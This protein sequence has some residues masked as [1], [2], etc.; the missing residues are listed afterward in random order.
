LV[1]FIALIAIVRTTDI[2]GD[3]AFANIA[4]WIL[5][6]SSFVILAVWFNFRSGFSRR[7]KLWT[8]AGFLAGLAA[9]VVLFRIERLSGELSPTF[10]F[11]FSAK[12]DR[13]LQ[14][15]DEATS[16]SE[17][18]EK[19]DLLATTEND[20]PQ[21]LGPGR[22]E[23]VENVKLARPWTE[24]QIPELIWKNKIGAGWS[25]FSVVGEH[26]VTMEQRG[27][28][29]MVTCYNVKSGKLEWSHADRARYEK[30]EA[31]VGPRGTPTIDGRLVF[32]QGALGH[33]MCLDGA[34]GKCVWEKNLLK[35]YNIPLDDANHEAIM[36]WGRSASPLV[37]GDWVIVP[38]GGPQGGKLV[39][40]AA[41]DK[42]TGAPVWE[43]GEKQASYCS[44]ALATLAGIEQVLIANEDTLAGH[45]LKTGRQ[46]WEYP[47]P[48]H[49]NRDPNVSQAVP[50]SPNR[51]FISKGYGGGSMLLEL[52][53]ADGGKFETRVVWKDR[54][55]MKSKFTN[56][57]VYDG[58]IYGLS[59]GVLECIEA[60]TGKSR[61]KQGRYGHGQI[62]G[63]GDLL[64]VLSEEGEVVLVEAT[65]E[66]AGN[67]LGRFQAI[68]GLTW[69]NLALSG[70]YLLVRNAQEAAC[71]KLPIE[72]PQ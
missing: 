51:V 21:F 57:F 38:I 12:S 9:L 1:V 41:F 48:G 18:K 69:N 8:L 14:P 68:D 13:L 7:C 55:V 35:D 32:A 30:L 26:A 45:D 29:E 61:W 50:I 19:I 42:R 25:A 52:A 62:L 33:L 2:L 49:T 31:G 24:K 67:V 16:E 11:R 17:P 43:G 22:N 66:R 20:F 15:P 28:W 54:R 60:A 36:I 27:D 64:L 10:A 6:F 58:H 39:S 53:P 37:V 44:P 3:H 63:V 23:R 56:V 4:T 59:D 47:W 46:L 40:L 5:S 65:P 70:S 72:A 71:Y 34:T